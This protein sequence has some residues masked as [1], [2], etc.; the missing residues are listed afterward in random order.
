MLNMNNGSVRTTYERS[1]EPHS[2][3]GIIRTACEVRLFRGS[4]R[5][6]GNFKCHLRQ[7]IYLW[8]L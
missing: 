4:F 8:A 3:D 7:G 1:L 2:T 6:A 5:R